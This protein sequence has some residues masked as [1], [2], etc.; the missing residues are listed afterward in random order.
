MLPQ[1]PAP[2][3]SR[4]GREA[5][6]FRCSSRSARQVVNV[7]TPHG[8]SVLVHVYE[9]FSL[10]IL[11][12]PSPGPGQIRNVSGVFCVPHRNRSCGCS[13][14]GEGSGPDFANKHPSHARVDSNVLCGLVCRSSMGVSFSVDSLQLL[15]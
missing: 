6:P 13:S 7:P 15:Q 2:P 11:S 4:D 8:L 12:P 1:W 9:N 10:L 3:C 5:D 14:Q